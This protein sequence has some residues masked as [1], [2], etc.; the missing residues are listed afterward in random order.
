MF[1]AEDS[2]KWASVDQSIMSISK[3]K[4]DNRVFP[5]FIYEPT[6]TIPDWICM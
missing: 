3:R 5:Y 6:W 4:G 2:G 1:L